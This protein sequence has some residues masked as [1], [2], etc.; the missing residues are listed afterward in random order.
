LTSIKYSEKELEIANTI[1][2]LF[3]C[4]FL[5][6]NIERE[7]NVVLIV[8]FVSLINK[9]SVFTSYL[10]TNL[11]TILAYQVIKQDLQTL[12]KNS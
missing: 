12:H 11:F 1:Q 9:E 2:S 6:F 5:T 10:Y 3:L 4:V 8:N 7:E